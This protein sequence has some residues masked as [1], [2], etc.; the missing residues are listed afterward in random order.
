M[1]RLFTA[2][3]YHGAATLTPIVAFAYAIRGIGDYFR[4]VFAINK[5]PYRNVTVMVWSTGITLLGC[6]TLIPRFKAWGAAIATLV[7]FV[8]MGIVA[9]QQA[10]RV[11]SFP[12]EWRRILQIAVCSALVTVATVAL[13][14][15]SIVGQALAACAAMAAFGLLLLATGFVY[16][17]EWAALREQCRALM[18]K[19]RSVGAAEVA[20]TR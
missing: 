18:R 3:A 13:R 7:A 16:P 20:E 6:M 10:R 12:Y 15:E 17:D 14:P 4:G 2:S 19:F 1:L 5:Q 11:Q 9:F 8:G